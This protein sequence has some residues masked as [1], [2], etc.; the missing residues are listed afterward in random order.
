METGLHGRLRT[1]PR[2]RAGLGTGRGVPENYNAAMASLTSFWTER[3]TFRPDRADP[4]L[5]LHFVLV[6]VRDQERSLRFYT[7]Q[8][9]F[10]VVVDFTFES[11]SRWIEVAPPDG[12]AKLALVPAVPGS[13]AEKRIGEF[14]NIYFLTEDVVAKYEEW[15]TRGVH[16]EFPPE[17]PEWG[18]MFTRFHDI[19]GNSFGLAGFDEATRAVETQRRAL[20]ARA[21]AERRHAQEIDIAKQVQLRLLPQRLPARASVD[22][23]GICLQARQVG[24]DYYD[25]L[26]LGQGVLCFAIADISGKGLGAALLMA[27]LQAALRSHSA[28]AIASPERLASTL[29]QLFYEN[30]AESAY[31]TLLLATFRE[32][33]RRVTYVNCGHLPGLIARTDGSIT[34]LE[35]TGTVIGLFE[36]WNCPALAC[37]LHPGDVLVIY[38]DAVTE[39]LNAAG[40]DFGHERLEDVIQTHRCLD[41]EALAHSI[42]DNVRAFS[43]GEQQDDITVL[44]VKC[45]EEL[46]GHE[47]D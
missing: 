18:G 5:H 24:G 26:D 36:R 43:S 30:T 46:R 27:N 40:E 45:K 47:T 22:F 4:Y 38:T 17:Q 14:T 25:C 7:E 10:T 6:C 31:A 21:E 15:R 3:T 12:T 32:D 16:F 9:G 19:D 1:V 20:A 28:M 23:V 2:L 34:R 11:G 13:E 44:V 29:N 41:A 39:S 33:T 35:S 42:I 8:L 37:D